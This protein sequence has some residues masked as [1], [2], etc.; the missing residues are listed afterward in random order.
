MKSKLLVDKPTAW[1]PIP[2][3][4]YLTRAGKTDMQNARS[5]KRKRQTKQHMFA[6]GDAFE[7]VLVTQWS[8]S[9]HS[10]PSFCVVFLHIH[11]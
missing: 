4:A 7:L 3:M 2:G 5:N 9:S 6:S 8:I 1:N 10:T 11:S